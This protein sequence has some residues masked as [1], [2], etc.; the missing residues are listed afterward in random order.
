MTSIDLSGK[1]AIVTGGGRGLGRA[2]TLALAGAGANVSAAMHIADDMG[3]LE[4]ASAGLPGKVNPVLSDIRKPEDCARVVAETVETF[5]GLH[6]LVNNAGVGM[7][8]VSETY[9]TVP[10]KFWD[11][12]PAAWQQII[13][14]NF[15]GAFQMA[16]EAVAHMLEQRWGRIVNVTTSLTTMQRRGYSPYG[17][18]KAALEAT[19]SAWAGDLEGTGVTAN[20]LIPGGA[21]DTHLLPG[22]PGTP[23]RMGADRQLIDPVVMQAPV[24]W[25]ASD[26]SNGVN[27]RRFIGKDWNAELPPD[28]GGENPSAPAGFGPRPEDFMP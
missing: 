13:D 5:G 28:R 20:V 14:T 8:L 25:L 6:V 4:A 7:L 11:A 10:S 24:V 27:G 2:M 17:P 15:V 19:T 3:P 22:E 9:N 26:H 23:G 21:A 1:T 16:R 18:S 12:T